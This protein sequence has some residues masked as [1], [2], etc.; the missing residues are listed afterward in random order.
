MH[1][2]YNNNDWQ[3]LLHGRLLCRQSNDNVVVRIL[4]NPDPS[5]HFLHCVTEF[6]FTDGIDN[7][8]AYC[9]EEEN[10]RSA[11]ICLERNID[12]LNELTKSDCNPE[13]KKAHQKR[14]DYNGNIDSC[15][16]IC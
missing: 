13:G 7:R 15:L 9:A 3:K 16:P 10:A 5:E 6:F 4:T 14:G 2:P 11:K 12:S 1:S 8:V